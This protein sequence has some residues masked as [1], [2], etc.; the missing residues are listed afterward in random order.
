MTEGVATGAGITALCVELLSRVS[1]KCCL[2]KYPLIGAMVGGRNR[3][4]IG[5]IGG[6]DPVCNLTWLY[7]Y[8]GIYINPDGTSANL[9]WAIVVMVLCSNGCLWSYL[10]IR[11][12]NGEIDYGR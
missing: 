1:T 4:T 11:Q 9:I 5:Q 8:T 10:C 7:L 2:R 3:R 12:K 6:D